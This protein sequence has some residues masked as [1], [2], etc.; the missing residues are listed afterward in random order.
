MRKAVRIS[1]VI[2]LLAFVFAVAPAAAQQVKLELKSKK[3]ERMRYDVKLGGTLD[4]DLKELPLPRSDM[5]WTNAK[6][7]GDIA[8]Y[9]ETLK[10]ENGLMTFDLKA[11]MDRLLLGGLIKL[12][13]L[14]MKSTLISPHI[15]MTVDPSIKIKTFDAGNLDIPTMPG[16]AAA[17][18]LPGMDMLGGGFGEIFGL[19]ATMMPSLLPTEPVGVGSTWKKEINFDQMM[20]MGSMLPRVPFDFKLVSMDGDVANIA[21][22]SKGKYDGAVLNTF[23]ALIPEIPLGDDVLKIANVKLLVNWDGAGTMKFDVAQGRLTEAQMSTVYNI[24]IGATTTFK[25]PDDSTEDWNPDGTI[26]FVL[27]FE[28]KYA[29]EPSVDEI[30]T[31]FPEPVKKEPAKKPETGKKKPAAKGGKKI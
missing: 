26:K 23:L 12:D 10:V 11:N 15:T 20:G 21:F 7:G 31:L 1:S 30:K 4:M 17:P 9:L 5:K 27:D 13:G 14:G 22:S 24:K 3:G 25:H 29:G 28:G 2:A 6:V 18:K 16:G 8:V 19:M